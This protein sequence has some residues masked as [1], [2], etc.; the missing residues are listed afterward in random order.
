MSRM[1]G[2][3]SAAAIR[4]GGHPDVCTVP[5]AACSANACEEDKKLSAPFGMNCHL[6]KPL[7]IAE[8]EIVLRRFLLDDGGE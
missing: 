7:E 6:P 3:E 8:L 2:Y 5:I 4:A 1:D